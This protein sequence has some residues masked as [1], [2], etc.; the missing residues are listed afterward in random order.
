MNRGFACSRRSSVVR[1]KVLHVAV[2]N[3]TSDV[4]RQSGSRVSHSAIACCDAGTYA[5]L[6]PTHKYADSASSSACARRYSVQAARLRFAA[7]M[8]LSSVSSLTWRALPRVGNVS[9]I[10]SS[11]AMVC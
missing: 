8:R 5:Q 1:L 6:N 2:L 7:C 4:S 3:A 11:G 10:S 9:A